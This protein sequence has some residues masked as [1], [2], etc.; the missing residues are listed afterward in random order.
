MLFILHQAGFGNFN[1]QLFGADIE[2][3]QGLLDGV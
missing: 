3:A 2:I 1:F